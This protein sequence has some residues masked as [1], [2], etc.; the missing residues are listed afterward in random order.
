MRLLACG[1]TKP[2][3]TFAKPEAPWWKQTYRYPVWSVLRTWVSKTSP[4]VAVVND[5]LAS[6]DAGELSQEMLAVAADLAAIRAAGLDESPPYLIPTAPGALPSY[7]ANAKFPTGAC[8]DK[9][10]GK[11]RYPRVLCPLDPRT[12]RQIDPDCKPDKPGDCEPDMID[13]L[14]GFG[15]GVVVFLIFLALV[16]GGKK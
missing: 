9:K 6:G 13:P 4:P 7:N 3:D 11:L 16:F 15:S 12:G 14:K 1:W 8:R 10:T 2:G 5:K